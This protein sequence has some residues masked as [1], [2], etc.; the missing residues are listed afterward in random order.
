MMLEWLEWLEGTGLGRI[1]R[2]SLYGFQVL[3]AIHIL[4]LIFSIGT[5]L[6]VDLR[7]MGLSLSDRPFSTVYRSLSKWFVA[8]FG[9][10]F[11]SGA[12]LFAGFA[13]SAYG[14]AYFRIKI[15]MILLAGINALA[16]HAIMRRSPTEAAG[17]IPSLRIRLAGFLSILFWGVTVL[18]GRMMSYTLF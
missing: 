11:L 4:G 2:E 8:G 7:M 18:C 6:W 5:L 3:V 13:T 17:Q 15:S 9:I 1:A 14:N 12:A 16:F 10:M